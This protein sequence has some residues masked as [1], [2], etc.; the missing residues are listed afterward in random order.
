VRGDI[1]QWQLRGSAA[2]LYERYLVPIVTWQWAVDLVAR[3]EVR[4]GDGLLDVACGTGVVARAAAERVG[5]GGRVVGLDLNS[6]MLAVARSFPKV[7]AVPM[8]WCEG[9]ALALP[10]DAGEF[11][12]VLCQFG[13]Q[14]FPDPLAALREMRRVLAPAGR[15]GVSVFAE[16]ERNPVAHAL[17]DALD[18][19]LGEGASFAKRNEH[20]LADR[21]VVGSLFPEAGFARVRIETVEKTSRYPSVSDYVRFQL[22]ATPLAAVLDPYDRPERDRLTTLVV[23]ELATRLATFVRE[24]EFAF[25]QVA[26]IA[27]AIA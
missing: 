24:R 5:S 21:D 25:P 18:R 26:H 23:D 13:L 14:F 3:V 11:G 12:V 2:E 7:G 8:E 22:Q 16:I 6:E 9:S 17:S 27:T 15:V 10:F 19:Q 4:R 1:E 20:A